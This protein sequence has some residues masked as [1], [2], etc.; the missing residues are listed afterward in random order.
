LI[1]GDDRVTGDVL[2]VTYASALFLDK[3]VASSKPVYVTGIHVTGPD[4]GNYT[5]KDAATAAADITPR[6]LNLLFKDG[7]KVY[8]GKIA[9]S[10]TPADDRVSGDVLTV[11]YASALFADKKV[12]TA[13]PVI[14]SGIT[15]TGPDAGNYAYK[16]MTTTT[17]DITPRPLNLLFAGVNRVYDGTTAATV[18]P[19]DDRVTGDVLTVNYTSATF[20]DKKVGIAK[21]VSVTGILVAGPDAGNYT[22]NRA[23]ITTAEITAR[24][25]GATFGGVNKVYDGNNL[26]TL[27]ASDGRVTGDVLTVK[28]T[29]ATFGDK[30]VGIAKAVSVTG[31]TVTGPDAGNYAYK[32]A[33][34]T[35]ADITPRALYVGF[36]NGDK[37]YDGTALATVTPTDDRVSGDVITVSYV[38]ATF[39]NKRAGVGKPVIVTGVHVTGPDAGDYAYKD[40]VTGAAAITKRNLNVGLAAQSKIYD[41][42]TAVVVTHPPADDRVSG[43]LI[44]I[45]IGSAAFADKKV[46]TAKPVTLTG[47]T[48]TGPDA[49]NYVFNSTVN[50]Y[51][52]ITPRELNV[53]LTPQNKVYDGTTDATVTVLDDRV[54]GDALT[55][56]V[57]AHFPDKKVGPAKSL[58]V[59][60]PIVSGPDAP[61]Y[62]PVT[63]HPTPLTADITARPLVVQA[64][65]SDRNYDGT[66]NATVTLS[67]NRIPGDV[68]TDGYFGAAFADKNAGTAK[69]VVVTGI[70]IVGDDAANYTAN[71]TA[72]TTANMNRRAITV[73]P[74]GR[75]KFFDG[76]TIAEVTLADDG[77]DFDDHRP[78][79][80]SAAFNDP[81]VG[82]AKPVTVKGIRIEGADGPNYMPPSSTATTSADITPLAANAAPLAALTG[83]YSDLVTF[84]ATVS[85]AAVSAAQVPASGV[86]FYVGSQY[87]GNAPLVQQPSLLGLVLKASLTAPLLESTLSPG[88]LAPGTHAVT[89]VLTGINSNFTVNSPTPGTLTITRRM[90]AQ[91]IPARCT[92]RRPA[93]ARARPR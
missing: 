15:V 89:A 5:Y 78:V 36:K 48:V 25:L 85:T 57:Q 41:G 9:A 86:S 88:Q 54:P 14:V 76:N 56:G 27:T 6:G 33:A 24:S 62:S 20:G 64:K 30:H 45:N 3:N 32:D 81:N 58:T 65:G 46:G 52:D 50:T 8:D 40:L 39:S 22:Y 28:Y 29:S 63:V 51:A 7:D 68:F 18:T 23:A 31:I 71:N 90:R 13:K 75:P 2:T 77:V 26:A 83:Q 84:A 92:P 91:P 1:A 43:D 74:T 34:T 60:G 55:V 4:A 38:D 21:P 70:T 37:G 87:V 69:P 12:A 35:A 17:A 59:V 10:V 72:S 19:G 93:P 66:T 73:T 49:D 80:D 61:N 16:D 11:N 44:T 47:I 82:T 42:T 53:R 67:D 79:Y